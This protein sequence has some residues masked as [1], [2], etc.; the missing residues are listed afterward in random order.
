MFSSLLEQ[1]IVSPRMCTVEYLCDCQKF[2][3]IPG[4]VNIDLIHN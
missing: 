3:I 4:D 1:K 2:Y